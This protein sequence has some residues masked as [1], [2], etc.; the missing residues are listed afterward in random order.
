MLL[1]HF[2][3]RRGESF[4]V[5][6]LRRSRSALVCGVVVG[7]VLIL[8]SSA[9]C[10]EDRKFDDPKDSEGN[11]GGGGELSERAC[12][13]DV[14]CDDG[15]ACNG[16]ETCGDGFCA[17]GEDFCR[18]AE[19]GCSVTCS[20]D[21]GEATCE[22]SVI[23]AD[24]DG[25]VSVDNE[26]ELETDLPRDDCDDDEPAVHG[27]A[28]EVCDGLDNDCDGLPDYKE[29]FE[30]GG[31][32]HT[33]FEGGS[34]VVPSGMVGASWSEHHEK[35]SIVFAMNMKL[36]VILL[37]ADGTLALEATEMLSES[38]AISTDA[39]GAVWQQEVLAVTYRMSGTGGVRK[40]ARFKIEVN[41]KTVTEQGTRTSILGSGDSYNASVASAGETGF[42]VLFN[43]TSKA[44]VQRFTASGSAIAPLIDLG[45]AGWQDAIVGSGSSVT[46]IWMRFEFDESDESIGSAFL[47]K[48]FSGAS[49]G[50]ETDEEFL[51]PPNVEIQSDGTVAASSLSNGYFAMTR[52][53]AGEVHLARRSDNG[54][55]DCGPV[56][57][58]EAPRPL[59]GDGEVRMTA[60]DDS[61]FYLVRSAESG[62]NEEIYPL[63]LDCDANAVGGGLVTLDSGLKMGS[64]IYSLTSSPGGHLIAVS[65]NGDV[66]IRVRA[67]GNAF[68]D[69][70]TP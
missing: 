64:G 1:S 26:C 52:R 2:L 37:H 27:G 55:S 9:G 46:A 28:E 22:E 54:D 70:A 51:V 65:A 58:G 66:D 15:L 4:D 12:E 43:K 40:F 57:V 21:A 68:C 36:W 10:S 61:A 7:V 44:Y 30:L 47:T 53:R 25:H 14:D 6:S 45:A 63:P 56:Q 17:S 13:R 5:T 32:V 62:N 49:L 59:S 20:E 24:E 34:G 23:D 8:A 41:D 29:G 33:V 3:R 42:A 69:A 19:D 48:T 16:R 60:N 11:G 67:F 38:A 31:E 50:T 35:W 18:A 39:L